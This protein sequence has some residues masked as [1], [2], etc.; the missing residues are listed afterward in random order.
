MSPNVLRVVVE[1]T[2]PL[3]GRV[4]EN[5]REI[6]E[7][8]ATA[9]EADLILFP[10]LAL[11]G[12][13]LGHRAP[14]LARPLEPGPEP[15]GMTLPET[16]PAVA[17]GYAERGR[18]SLVYNGA[19]V[20]RGREILARHRKIYLPTYG[21]FDEG[22][23]FAPGREGPPVFDVAGWRVGLLICEE[24]WHPAL[25][26]LLALQEADLIMVL[27]AAAGRGE[28]GEGSDS[29]F[30]SAES[31]ELLAR[32]TAFN[33]GVWLV[34]ANRAGVEEGL[35]FAGGSLVVDPTGQVVARA[36]QGNTSRLRISLDRDMIRRARHPFSHLRDEDP[37]LVMRELRRIIGRG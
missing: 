30:A 19:A 5:V 20:L 13:L 17:L 11:T 32:A 3:R 6:T 36:D 14:S 26:Y 25:P 22:R 28:P 21:M 7:A 10:E 2:A 29:L 16:G 24:L 23:T 31:W 33:H 1:Q 15:L 37:G 8:V 35:T 12:Y 34:M 18:D 27:S 4:E 9:A